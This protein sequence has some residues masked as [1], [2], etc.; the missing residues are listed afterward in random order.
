MQSS[1]NQWYKF[2]VDCIYFGH[3]P[4]VS[5][6]IDI[7]NLLILILVCK[8]K[9]MVAMTEA[10]ILLLNIQFHQVW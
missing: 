4:E 7:Q 8:H 6:Y 1:G 10:F 5:Y 9:V 2:E 3:I